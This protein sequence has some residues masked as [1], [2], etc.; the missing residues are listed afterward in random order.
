MLHLFSTPEHL[1][2]DASAAFDFTGR[3]RT[4]PAGRAHA[5]LPSL[6]DSARN[7]PGSAPGTTAFRSCRSSLNNAVMSRLY[8]FSHHHQR[9]PAISPSCRYAIGGRYAMRRAL[10]RTIE[11]CALATMFEQ[12]RAGYMPA[13]LFTMIAFSSS[14]HQPQAAYTP[15][16]SPV[17]QA[18][19]AITPAY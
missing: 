11:R 14:R 16:L 12:Q 8:L 13:R 10:H 4:L 1:M 9:R 5:M 15:R 19:P 6:A 3:R 17:K 18:M 2:I 7:A